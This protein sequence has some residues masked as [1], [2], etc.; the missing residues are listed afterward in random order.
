MSALVMICFYIDRFAKIIAL[1][2]VPEESFLW[3]RYLTLG[4]GTTR[5]ASNVRDTEDII[6][7]KKKNSLI[8]LAIYAFFSQTFAVAQICTVLTCLRANVHCF[9]LPNPKYALF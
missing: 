6:P 4:T 2:P 5:V 8:F 9:D 7:A 1:V 3:H